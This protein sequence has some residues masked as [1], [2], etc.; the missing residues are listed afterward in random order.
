MRNTQKESKQD[1]HLSNFN[2]QVMCKNENEKIEHDYFEDGITKKGCVLVLLYLWGNWVTGGW[3][4]CYSKL[5]LEE[6]LRE[7]S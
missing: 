4:I 2:K 3:F 7:E 1:S 5:C 6:K